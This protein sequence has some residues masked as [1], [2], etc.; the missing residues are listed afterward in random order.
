MESKVYHVAYWRYEPNNAPVNRL[1]ALTKGLGENGI[2]TKVYFFLPDKNHSKVKSSYPNVEFVYLW[3]NKHSNNKLICLLRGLHR[4]YSLVPKDS[5]LID[6]SPRLLWVFKKFF[7]CKIYHERTENPD[8]VRAFGNNLLEKLY[9]ITCREIDGLFVISPSLK[10]YF[11]NRVNVSNDKIEIINMVV[12]TERFDNIN[13]AKKDFISYCGKISLY[14][15]GVD[16]LIR[17][18]AKANIDYNIKLRIIGPFESEY[19]RKTIMSLVKGLELEKRVVFTGPVQAEDMPKLLAESKLLVLARPNN[20]Q[21]KYGFPTKMGEYLST[22]VPVLATKVGDFEYYLQ[23]GYNIFLA[24]PDNV[25]DFSNKIASIFNDYKDS[26]L[27][28]ENGKEAAKKLFCYNTES[29]KMIDFIENDN[30]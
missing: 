4:F 21:S 3:E 23:N 8:I 28:G 2:I 22:G 9:R 17:S 7:K 11:H 20:L 25:D 16:T 5:V 19:T 13:V 29:K 6:Y 26:V 1:L 12:D 15:D 30:D 27:V 24:E 14:K 18:F 10:E